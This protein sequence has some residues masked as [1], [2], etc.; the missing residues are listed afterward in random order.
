MLRDDGGLPSVSFASMPGMLPM[1]PFDSSGLVNAESCGTW[2][3]AAVDS[4]TVSVAR[5]SIPRKASH[6]FQKACSDFKSNKLKAAETHARQAVKIYPDYAAAWVVLGEIFEAEHRDNQAVGACRHGLTADPRY[7]PPYIC[8]ADFA[9]DAKDWDET[10]ALADRA[11][12]L[13]PATDPYAFL[14]TAT[15]DFH[16]QRYDQAELYGLSAEKLDIWNKIPQVH[17]LLA[18][19]YEMER[20]R[21]EEVQELR[22]YVKEAPHD[23]NWE[24]ARAKL[25]ELRDH[26]I[27]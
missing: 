15:A 25:N 12:A 14:Y 2:T 11:L 17:L 5:L 7:A 22:K 24:L 4:P 9:A 20:K 19:V 27:E 10:Y 21:H 3:A 23:S 8:L 6:Q 13:D 26:L 18:D 16:L 1:M